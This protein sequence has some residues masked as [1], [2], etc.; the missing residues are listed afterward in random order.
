MNLFVIMS[1]PYDDSP[2]FWNN[3]EGWTDL[4]DATVFMESE[5]Y[6]VSLPQE[7]WGWVQLPEQI[8]DL[9]YAWQ[10]EADEKAA[11]LEDEDVF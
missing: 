10:Y 3:E 9:V 1:D 11:A 5:R 6:T 2:L 4:A 7:A 8:W